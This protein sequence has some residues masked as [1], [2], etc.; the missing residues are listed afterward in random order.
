[1]ATLWQNKNYLTSLPFIVATNIYE[2][3]IKKANISIL[4]HEGAIDKAG[5]DRLYALPKIQRQ[6][7]IG[8]MIK[9]NP[10]I[11]SI[12]SDGIKE[13][14]RRFFEANSIEDYNVVSIKNDAVFL[15]ND[16]PVVTV[17]DNVEFVMKN[18]YSSF[19]KLNKNIEIYFRSDR[20]NNSLQFD[21]KGI[22]DEVLR[23]H[24]NHMCSWLAQIMYSIEVGDI[25]LAIS[26]IQIFFDDFVNRRLPI[27]FY[28]TFDP[29]S[30][31]I[32]IANG[33]PYL[34]PHATDQDIDVLNI[35]TNV[36]I[37]REMYS[38][39]TQLYFSRNKQP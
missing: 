31:Y 15:I 26:D 27:E 39:C 19:Y 4:L 29:I 9:N 17:F 36:N 22:N 38:I 16:K 3:D 8:Y 24:Q 14:K 30:G 6:I 1:M 21:V 32:V 11:D 28:R 33:Q 2:Y 12:L 18:V 34:L 13:M 37:I 35:T 5:Y 20:I 23:L 10:E 7:E 25:Q